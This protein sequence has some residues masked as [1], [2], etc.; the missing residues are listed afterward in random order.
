MAAKKKDVG[1]KIPVTFSKKPSEEIALRAFLF[2]RK[3]KLIESV[4]VTKGEAQFKAEIKSKSDA[5]LLIVPDR[6]DVENETNLKV[7]EARY[8]AYKPILTLDAKRKLTI[9]PIPE[10]FFPFWFFKKCNVTD[11]SCCFC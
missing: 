2:D 7:L 9:L 5:Q 8:K 10:L 3:G 4:P 6:E 11:T 1:F